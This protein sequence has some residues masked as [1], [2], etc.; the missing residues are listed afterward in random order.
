MSQS[1]GSWKVSLP[2]LQA[3]AETVESEAFPAISSR[4]V[5]G[6]NPPQ[7]VIE[8]FLPNE[9]TEAQ[10][11]AFRTL[12]PSAADQ[13]P[14]IEWLAPADW[15]TISQAGLD[16]VRA[17]RFFV[18]TAVHAENVPEDMIAFRIEAGQAFG[19][20]QHETTTGCLLML[21][22][23]RRGGERFRNIAD[24]GTGTGLLAFA[25]LRLWP[26]ANVI[27]SDIDPIAIAVAAENAE[28]NG[29]TLGTRPGMVELV[30]APG[31]A[32]R[33]LRRRAP[34]DLIIANILAG[35]LIDLAP[36]LST[37]LAPG[38]TLILA[39][40]LDHQADDVAAAYRRQGLRLAGDIMGGEWPTLRL[41]KRRQ[42]RP[43]RSAQTPRQ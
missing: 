7:W 14:N 12:V 30:T 15:L 43:G 29:V 18:H 2:C 9:P 21:D 34:F 40:L 6:T 17:G 39:G 4:E 10:I 38:G 27:A 28:V 11:A 26:G 1:T 5:E 13:P 8:A 23:L 35:P 22:Q 3:E 41:V 31:M 36:V 20:G 25:A 32:H 19:T 16:P 33:R 37:A 24:I 42:I